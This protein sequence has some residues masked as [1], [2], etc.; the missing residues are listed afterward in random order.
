[1][2][3][4]RPDAEPK[5]M[6]VL[7]STLLAL[8][9]GFFGTRD[10]SFSIADPRFHERGPFLQHSSEDEHL[11]VELSN[12]AAGYWPTAVFELAHESVHLL[13]PV[14]GYTNTLEEG[15]AVAF[16]HFVA[17]V[18]SG[19]AISTTLDSYLEAERLVKE[20]G[21]DVFHSGKKIRQHFRSFSKVN[22]DSLSKLFP[23]SK[24]ELLE[25]LVAECRPRPR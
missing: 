23:S 21:D 8:A 16:Q 18:L 1:M 12:N 10:R 20:L 3:R 11:W 4:I 24:P 9:E 17:P 7:Q 25:K 14:K 5:R 15:F 19:E 22:V 6:R 13:N 2:P